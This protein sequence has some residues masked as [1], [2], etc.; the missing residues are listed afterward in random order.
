MATPNTSQAHSVTWD[1][2]MP[3]PRLPPLSMPCPAACGGVAYWQ[4]HTERGHEYT[5]TSCRVEAAM[6]RKTAWLF[7]VGFGTQV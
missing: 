1:L 2:P 7:A 6:S 5:C 4:G 3:L